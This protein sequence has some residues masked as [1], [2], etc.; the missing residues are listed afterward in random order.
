MNRILKV[1][2]FEVLLFAA[3]AS[4]ASADS[5]F[6]LAVAAT[7]EQI[8]QA[9]K[10]SADVNARNEHGETP[11]MWAARYNQN[12]EIITALVNAGADV[13][14]RD[15]DGSTPLM[16]A[17]FFNENHRVMLALLQASADSFILFGAAILFCFVQ[18]YC[19]QLVYEN[20]LDTVAICAAGFFLCRLDAQRLAQLAYFFLHACL[21][22]AGSAA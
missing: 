13:N 9:I 2:V 6:D 11:L 10:A 7:P 18:E 12:P 4:I 5:L 15:N 19:R 8:E 20:G 21:Q 1:L 14:A 22:C 3:A 17:A 16:H